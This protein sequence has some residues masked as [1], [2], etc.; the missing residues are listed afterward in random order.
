MADVSPDYLR[1][2]IVPHKLTKDNIWTSQSS[3]TQEGNLAGDPEPQQTSKLLVRSTGSQSTDTDIRIITRRA[4]HVGKGAG[5]TWKNNALASGEVGQDAYNSIQDF[6]YIGFS[7][8]TA[9]TDRYL[10]PYPLD[11]GNGTCLIAVQVFDTSESR[12]KIVVYKR[13]LDGAYTSV[14]VKNFSLAITAS[15][16]QPSHPILIQTPKNDILLCFLFEDTELDLVNLEVYR[17]SDEGATF[18]RISRRAFTAEISTNA[19]TGY[20][21]ARLRGAATAG[22]VLLFVETVFNDAGASK[23][24]R[25]FQYCSFDEGCNF[26]LVTTTSQ[27]DDYSFYQVDCFVRREQ[28]VLSYIADTNRAHYMVLPQGFHSV[29]VLRS[30]SR[31]V[32]SNTET[33]AGGTSGYMTSGLHTAFVDDNNTIY[34]VFTDSNREYVYLRYSEDG[35][36]FKFMNGD[37]DSENAACYDVS[38]TGTM[39]SNIKA[40]VCAGACFLFSNWSVTSNLDSSATNIKLGGFANVNLPLQKQGLQDFFGNRAGYGFTYLPLDLPT[41][42]TSIV[43]TG[44][45]TETLLASGFKISTNTTQTVNYTVATTGAIHTGGPVKI[46]GKIIVTTNNKGDVVSPFTNG[47]RQLKIETSNSTKSYSVS[48]IIGNSQFQVF[49]NNG[50][51]N[52]G[53]PVTVVGTDGIE[54]LFGIDGSNFHV[55]YKQANNTDSKL[56]ITGPSTSTLTDGGAVAVKANMVFSHTIATG[57]GTLDSTIKLWAGG[58]STIPSGG[59]IYSGIAGQGLGNGFTN[60]DDLSTALYPPTGTFKYVA[61]GIKITTALGPAFEGDQYK[62]QTRYN[63]PIEN[64]F[65]KNSPTPR[66]FWRSAAVTSGNVPEN[67]LAFA[68]DAASQSLNQDIGNNLFGI[69]LSNINFKEFNIEYYNTGAAAWANLKTVSVATGLTFNYQ[70]SNA[71]IV[72]LGGGADEPYLQENECEGWIAELQ[73][74]G[75]IERFTV[76][77]NTAGKC[78]STAFKRPVLRLDGVPSASGVCRLIPKNVTVLVNALNVA[79][80]AWGI[81]ITAQETKDKFFK[82]GQVVIGPVV[83]GTQYSWGRTINIE[84][85]IQ[86]YETP[87][88]VQFSRE[89]SPTRRIIRVGWT[90]GID[91]STVMGS[92]PTPDVYSSSTSTGAQPVASPQDMPFKIVGMFQYLNGPLN[93]VVY[94]PSIKRSTLSSTDVII[95]NRYHEHALCVLN[96]DAGIDNILGDE[97][98]SEGGELFRISQLTLTEVI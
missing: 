16:S 96:E 84:H 49:D 2:F 29:H 22:Q 10:Y 13:G 34:Q 7:D 68:L 81:R 91:I 95:L 61:E 66:V 18:T 33:I 46:T 23:R 76:I 63:H 79:A 5:F 64:V 98:V 73:Q 77:S 74:G 12:R 80:T 19:S 20:S 88:K 14:T 36:I 26:R 8:G 90:E 38:D 31:F 28:F 93:P 25:L 32:I 15:L 57:L 27:I 92:N 59:S 30:A 39:L 42:V 1:G 53:S 43:K 50:S 21:I 24:N 82:I 78:G 41:D 85:N 58:Y 45:S 17:T 37:R 47:K 67:F 35:Q 86:T 52:I 3:F 97:N 62:I 83:T 54:F 40:V 60:P 44:T 94:L 69:H 48:I 71:A 56:F 70:N 6:E 4:G 87:D 75:T 72:G 9:F 51:A 65:F 11:L 89:L 55:W